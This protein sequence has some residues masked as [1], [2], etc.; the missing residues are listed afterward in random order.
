MSFD[1]LKVIEASHFF[2]SISDRRASGPV[3]A[4]AVRAAAVLDAMAWSAGEGG[5]ARVT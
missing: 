1:D 4:D 3:L 2:R 5:W